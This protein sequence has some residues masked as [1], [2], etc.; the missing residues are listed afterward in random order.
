MPGTEVVEWRR[1][2]HLTH[3]KKSIS[4]LIPISKWAEGADSELFRAHAT[5]IP[6]SAYV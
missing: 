4:I 6:K 1:S 2:L 5:D 3:V